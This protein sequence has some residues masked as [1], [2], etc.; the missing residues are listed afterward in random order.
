M[1]KQG[2]IYV[3]TNESFHRENWIKIGYAEDVNKRVKELSGTAVPIPYEIYCTYEI[4]RINGEKDPDKLVHDLIQALNPEL[5]ISKNREFFELAPWDAY[6]MLEAIAKMHN[7][8]DKLVKNKL[9]KSDQEIKSELECSADKLF[10]NGSE[11]R[12]L[13]VSL[14]EI[15]LSVDPSLEESS[16]RIYVA[17]KKKNKIAISLW[18]RKKCIEVTLKAKI[19]QIHDNNNLLYDITNRQWISEQY[20]FKYYSDTDTEIVKDIIKQTLE[21]KK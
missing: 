14:R 13:Y 9:N 21:L 6:N 1:N 11:I 2:Y 20:A 8:M 5:R 7:R 3:L 18:P 17:F 16:S 12:E 15:L 10:P 19:G 4:P